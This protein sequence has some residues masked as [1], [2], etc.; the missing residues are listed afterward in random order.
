MI[1]ETERNASSEGK[2]INYTQ[3]VYTQTEC[4]LTS[5]LFTDNQFIPKLDFIFN[6]LNFYRQPVYNQTGFCLTS[7]TFTDKQLIPKLDFV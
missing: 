5:Q 1:S 6:V 3:T 4:G 7:Q 2:L